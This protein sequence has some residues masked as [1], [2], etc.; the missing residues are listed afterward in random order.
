MA[1]KPSELFFVQLSNLLLNFTQIC[2]V[3]F[4]ISAEMI[5]AKIS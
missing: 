4:E 2:L 1:P 5:I 3:V